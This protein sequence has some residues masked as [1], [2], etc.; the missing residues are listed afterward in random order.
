[1]IFTFQF[2]GLVHRL[3]N[4]IRRDVLGGLVLRHAERL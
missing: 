3:P 2:D 4:S 1:M